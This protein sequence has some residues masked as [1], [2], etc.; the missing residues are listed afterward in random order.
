MLKIFFW[1][2]GVNTGGVK[3]ANEL[4]LRMLAAWPGRG[5]IEELGGRA[6]AVLRRAEAL[7]MPRLLPAS[8]M[9]FRIREE[10]Y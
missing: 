2:F 1:C 6:N 8:H 7:G 9:C 4:L 5:G 10:G 3:N